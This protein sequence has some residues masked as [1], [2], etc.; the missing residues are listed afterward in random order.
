VLNI[1]RP[2][3]RMSAFMR[4]EIFEVLRQ[5]RLVLSL[6]LGP[7]L[8]LLLFCL[9]FHNEPRPLRTVFV[10]QAGSTLSQQ[11]QEYATSLG[12][13][14]LFMGVTSDEQEAR[15]RL[16][17][18]EVDLV[19]I[20][21]ADAYETIQ[22]SEQA[23]FILLHDELD[24]FQQDYVRVF[25]QVYTDEVNRRIMQ[26]ITEEG[27]MEAEAVQEALQRGRSSAAAMRQALEQGD[28]ATARF[29]QAGLDRNMNIVALAVGTSAGLLSSVQET[30]GDEEA[31]DSGET[32]AYLDS[33]R[34][35]IGVL[36]ELPAQG[37]YRSEIDELTRIEGQI[38]DL[39]TQLAEFQRIEPHILVS[40]FGADVR[41]VAPVAID[42]TDYF[43]PSV[44]VLLLQHLA[45]TIA[46]LSIVRERQL[47]TLELFRVAPL[48]AGETLIGKYVSNLFFGVLLGVALLLLL[49]FGLGV[50]ILGDWVSVLVILLV[51]LFS[52]LGIGFV[53]SLTAQT[54]S[55]AVQYAMLIL[56]LT[57][58]FSGFFLNLQMFYPPVR[59]L[60]YLLPATYGIE[61]LQGVMLRGQPLDGL[62]LLR[63]GGIGLVLALIS[64][65]LMRRLMTHE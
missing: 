15:N 58:F 24:P 39:E 52:S 26:R 14:L 59:A 1:F 65:F 29:H 16:R 46:G 55:Q 22:A 37:N 17:R 42:V 36:G 53:I 57:V 60:S 64:W 61:L 41:N 40:P 48:T 20:T 62:N 63:L 27:Q 21:P 3:I 19:V 33:L 7:F 11:V 34:Q 18:G 10:A 44:V 32:M 4:R 47:G 9:L 5:P 2:F 38:D 56:L 35:A 25:G 13:Q 31:Q 54:D 30:L 51:L 45:V 50:P 28:T 43:A 6:V 8:I 23:Q 49:V 12:P